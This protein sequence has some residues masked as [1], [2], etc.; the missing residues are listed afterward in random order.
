[1][2]SRRL[3]ICSI[4]NGKYTDIPS[5]LIV[6]SGKLV[7]ED[8]F[9]GYGRNQTHRMMSVSKSIT[10]ILLGISDF[11]WQKLSDGT[12]NTAWGLRLKPRDMA[13]IGYLML[14]DGKWN[15]KQIVSPNWVKESTKAHVEGDILLGPGYGYQWWRGRTY[16]NNKDIETFYCSC[17]FW[18]LAV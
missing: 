5:V 6:K 14:K 10:S 2:L 12:I 15:D 3:N 17:W 7:F 13:K 9:Y 11:S 18:N 1:M 8:Y 16:I 4:L